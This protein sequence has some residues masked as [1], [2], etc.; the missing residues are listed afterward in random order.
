MTVAA[1]LDDLRAGLP[2]CSLVVFGDFFSQITL[3]VSAQDR[4]PQER[5][6]A[7]C[8]SA[9][10]LLDGPVAQ[11]VTATM[12]MPDNHAFSQAILFCPTSMQIFLRS[13]VEEAD[14]L[15]CVLS[16]NGDAETAA[17]RARATLQ[18]IAQ[19]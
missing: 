5:L 12:G 7:I 18:L 17:N 9:G 11:A 4:H 14:M 2:G 3:C 8:A 19:A 6:D 15:C 16:L 1:H 13:P 10:T